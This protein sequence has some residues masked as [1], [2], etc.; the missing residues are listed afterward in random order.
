[1]LK[2]KNI[3]EVHTPFKELA[4]PMVRLVEKYDKEF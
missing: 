3:G 1:M 2:G 4:E